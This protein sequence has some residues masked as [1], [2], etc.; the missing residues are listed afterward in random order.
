MALT[1]QNCSFTCREG[2][3]ERGIMYLSELFLQ[4]LGENYDVESVLT[5]LE[6]CDKEFHT[7]STETCD[8]QNLALHMKQRDIAE[9]SQYTCEFLDFWDVCKEFD[10]L[11]DEQQKKELEVLN[12]ARQIKAMAGR[13]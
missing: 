1:W 7:R 13:I 10:P 12:T 2:T 9:P 6:V 5:A 11:L 8:A 3:P 4:Q